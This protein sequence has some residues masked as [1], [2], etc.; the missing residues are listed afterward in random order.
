MK[1]F[2][3]LGLSE[4]ILTTVAN[5]GYEAPMPIQE[6]V[7]PFILSEEEDLVGLAQTGTGKTAAFGLPIIQLLDERLHKIQA[8]VLAPTRELCMQIA[9]DLTNYS[10]NMANIKVVPVYG[11]ENIVTQMQRLN[12]PPQMLVATPGRLIDLIERGKIKLEDVRYLVLDEADEM[13]NMGF[14]EDLKTILKTVPDT[15]R[16][17][18]FSATMPKTIVS[19]AEKYMKHY[20]EIMVGQRN[21]GA[22][23]IE[24]LYYYI[25]P[26]NRYLALKRIVDANPDIYGIVFCRT[27]RETKE[28]AD[29]LM[30]DGY[31]VDALH[32]DLSQ[33]Q[34]DTVMNKFRLRN[35]QILV[36]TDVAARGLDVN[37]LTHVINYGL[38]E[39]AEVYTHRSGRTGRAGKK[40]VSISIV[41]GKEQNR[42]SEIEKKLGQP[43][44]KELIPTGPEVCK[45]QLFSM[46]NKMEHVEVNYNEINLLLPQ[47]I[48]KLEYLDKEEIIRRFVSLE[49]NRFLD[50]YKD[51]ID[52]NSKAPS[53]KREYKERNDNSDR[54]SNRGEQRRKNDKGNRVRI[55]MNFG[56]KQNASPRAILGMINEVTNSNHIHV[57]DIEITPK[58]TYFDLYADQA[59]F[60]LQAFKNNSN[61]NLSIMTD[62]KRTNASS[63]WVER[64]NEKRDFTK[65]NRRG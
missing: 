61:F 35:L 27:R 21:A 24:H 63:S 16:T 39:D 22:E 59:D 36:A 40:G 46:I 30:K 8:L 29:E 58:F 54:Q 3:D 10:Q 14:E 65:K 15:R 28:V 9:Q 43:F 51:A 55:K 38:P 62:E 52:L 19:I 48:K 57:G 13:L 1:T 17:F 20:S 32:G 56:S 31:D 44:K 26:S 18:L 42:I 4:K 64:R 49:F 50:Y 41:G 60:L 45:R 2:Q 25:Q 12:T 34:R 23:N 37:D 6:R 5:L 33:A 7:I 11:G 53:S 47:V